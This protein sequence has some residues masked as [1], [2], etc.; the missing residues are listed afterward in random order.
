MNFV[1][2]Q[3]K[4]LKIGQPTHSNKNSDKDDNDNIEYTWCG[5]LLSSVKFEDSFAF[6]T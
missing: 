5:N 3:L 4:T 1:T 2:M 6:C